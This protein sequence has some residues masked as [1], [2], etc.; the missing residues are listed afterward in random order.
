MTVNEIYDQIKHVIVE[1]IHEDWKV[2][3]LFIDRLE[4]YVAAYC[5]YVNTKDEELIMDDSNLGF[6]F[7]LLIHE[8]YVVSTQNGENNW[9]KL[10]FTLS[11]SGDFKADFTWDQ[12]YQDEIDALNKKLK[13]K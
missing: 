5:K 6:S 4:G 11:P 9:N 3:N 7:S 1:S 8:L 2:A 12:A 13:K 10:K